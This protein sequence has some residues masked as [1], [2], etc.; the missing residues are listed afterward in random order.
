L[1]FDNNPTASAALGA[2]KTNLIEI[3]VFG[4]STSEGAVEF[5]FLA[6]NKG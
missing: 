1:R 5:F 3:R 6:R 2:G 4:K